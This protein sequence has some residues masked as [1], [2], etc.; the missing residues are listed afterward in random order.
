MNNWQTTSGGTNIAAELPQLILNHSIAALELLQFERRPSLRG[1]EIS[2]EARELTSRA[3][4]EYRSRGFG[5]WDVLLTSLNTAGAETQEAILTRAIEHN[6]TPG[7]KTVNSEDFVRDLANGT[8]EQLEGRSLVA[9]SSR[10][11]TNDGAIRHLPM[12]DFALPANTENLELVVKV[13][14]TLDADG[15]LFESGNSYH[16]IGSTLLTEQE[17]WQFLARA[18]LLGP[19]TDHRWISH[20]FLS[21]ECSLRISTDLETHQNPQTLVA[22]TLN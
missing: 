20:Q 14:Q 11:T 6:A 21:S 7:R 5:F 8:F 9:L 16:L 17:L 4:T 13:L 22:T 18:Q 19:I 12:L 1:R 2:E 10:V 3:R 15:Q